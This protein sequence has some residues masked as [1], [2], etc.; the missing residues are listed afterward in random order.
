MME[1]VKEKMGTYNR[2][3]ESDK[4]MILNRLVQKFRGNNSVMLYGGYAQ[5][6]LIFRQ[7]VYDAFLNKDNFPFVPRSFKSGGRVDGNKV[8]VFIANGNDPK[9]YTAETREFFDFIVR[10]GDFSDCFYNLNFSSNNDSMLLENHDLDIYSLKPLVIAKEIFDMC[11]ELGYNTRICEAIHIGT[12]SVKITSSD[13]SFYNVCDITYIPKFIFFNI[14]NKL[15]IDINGLRVVTNYLVFLDYYKMFSDVYCSNFRYEKVLKERIPFFAKHCSFKWNNTYLNIG[16]DF[17][18]MR[19]KDILEEFKY[20]PSIIT[21]GFMAFNKFKNIFKDMIGYHYNVPWISNQYREFISVNYN[22]DNEK[23]KKMLDEHKII[24]ETKEKQMFCY[25]LGKSTEYYYT[26]RGKK[27]LFCVIYGN[28]NISIPFITD[29]YRGRENKVTSHTYTIYHFLSIYLSQK[30]NYEQVTK[31]G[32]SPIRN[33]IN[34]DE[35]MKIVGYLQDMQEIVVQSTGITI[36]DESPFELITTSIVGVP[37][38]N[39]DFRFECKSD[40]T[41]FSLD[42]T[43]PDKY[44]EAQINDWTYINMSGNSIELKDI[45]KDKTS[46]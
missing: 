9:R 2:L 34:P 35:F 16:D 14:H 10:Y 8:K 13:G 46:D 12:Y 32:K 39:K 30:V 33:N 20:I 7:C 4:M 11:V 44:T 26:D 5:N 6:L 15:A 18:D 24:Y 38:N 3:T 22:I 23:L 25:Y 29:S 45:P 43:N 31:Y 19:L 36:M 42:S 21:T 17:L 37:I 40:Y 1:R 27:I 28:N 41:F